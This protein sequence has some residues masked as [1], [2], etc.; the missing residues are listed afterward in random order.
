M[1]NIWHVGNEYRTNSLSHEPGGEAVY[2]Y[3]NSGQILEYDRIK[4]PDAYIGKIVSN[5]LTRNGYTPNRN[6]GTIDRNAIKLTILKIMIN[7]N[8]YWKNQDSNIPWINWKKNEDSYY[9]N[10]QKFTPLTKTQKNNVVKELTSF[11]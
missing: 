6:R 8:V 10:Q 3:L 1:S 4:Y 9:N 7:G 11:Y 5:T 2:V